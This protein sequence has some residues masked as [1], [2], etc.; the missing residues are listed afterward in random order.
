MDIV[1]DSTGQGSQGDEVK[2]HLIPNLE[3][4]VH[5]LKQHAAITACDNTL[6]VFTAQDFSSVTCSLKVVYNRI[7]IL[8]SVIAFI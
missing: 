7:I 1:N 2:T 3:S 4:Y 8:I 5:Q 6:K